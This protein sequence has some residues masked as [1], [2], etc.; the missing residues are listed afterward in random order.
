MATKG[1]QIYFSVLVPGQ[2]Q[3]LDLVGF[4]PED[5]DGFMVSDKMAVYFQH[6]VTIILQKNPQDFIGS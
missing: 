5:L 1:D 4:I 2:Y 6:K 3:S